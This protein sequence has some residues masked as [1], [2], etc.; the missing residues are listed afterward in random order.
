MDLT[1][2]QFQKEHMYYIAVPLFITAIYVLFDNKIKF[3]KKRFNVAEDMYKKSMFVFFATGQLLLI[4]LTIHKFVNKDPEFLSNGFVVIKM[5]VV[6]MVLSIM[7]LVF[8]KVFFNY[9]MTG[10]EKTNKGLLFVIPIFNAITMLVLF[11]NQVSTIF[12]DLDIVGFIFRFIKVHESDSN[13]V[14]N[15]LYYLGFETLCVLLYIIAVNHS[16]MNML[17]TICGNLNVKKV[18]KACGD[19]ITNDIFAYTVFAKIIFVVLFLMMKL[20]FMV[21][22]L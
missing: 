6:S 12:T 20:L 1:K 15:I 22:K 16:S 13:I 14:T 19:E 18:N 7:A 17:Q 11:L 9:F 3:S 2:I 4:L 10:K 21:L 5:V 8:E